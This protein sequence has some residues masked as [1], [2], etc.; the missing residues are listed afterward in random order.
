[1]DYQWYMLLK[2]NR[3]VLSQTSPGQRI[4]MID[5]SGSY[6]VAQKLKR[7]IPLGREVRIYSGKSSFKKKLM[8]YLLPLRIS[9]SG[10]YIAVFKD[11]AV[12]FDMSR[13]MLMRNHNVI[14]ENTYLVAS[15]TPDTAL[16]KIATE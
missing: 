2:S 7:N 3:A 15:F 14:E 6:G 11:P 4:L 13:K 10:K 12:S 9:D 16:Y 1:M 5:R 8:Y